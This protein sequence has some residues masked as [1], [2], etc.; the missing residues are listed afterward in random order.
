L[1]HD[2]CDF[3]YAKLHEKRERERS[4]IFFSLSLSVFY[5]L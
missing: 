5:S 4:M 1:L 2:E 3:I